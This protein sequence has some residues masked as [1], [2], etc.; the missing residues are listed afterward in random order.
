MGRLC[1]SFW[2]NDLS[3]DCLKMRFCVLGWR[4]NLTERKLP[5][6][7]SLLLSLPCIICHI[8]FILWQTY[9]LRFEVI[10]NAIQ[11][12]F[13]GLEIIFSIFAFISFARFVSLLNV[14]ITELPSIIR[15]NWLEEI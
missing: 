9:V 2:R 7:I 5:L 11:L 8:Y 15:S 13:V 14:R 3:R 4:G 10:T 1:G 12:C 6:L